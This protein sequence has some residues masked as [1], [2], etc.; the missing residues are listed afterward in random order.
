MDILK[1]HHKKI[2]IVKTMPHKSNQFLSLAPVLANTMKR[3]AMK[4]LMPSL[5]QK[6]CSSTSSSLFQH[7]QQHQK[8]SY[9]SVNGPFN[10]RVMS[11]KE[12]LTQFIKGGNRVFLQTGMYN[13]CFVMLYVG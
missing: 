1:R 11:A 4:I 13:C 10:A 12:A 7:H 3:G 9:G 2:L 6:H 8:A 5:V